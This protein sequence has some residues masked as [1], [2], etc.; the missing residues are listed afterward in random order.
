MYLKAGIKRFS[1]KI[2]IS[3]YLNEEEEEKAGGGQ[4]QIPSVGL[5]PL[6]HVTL[7]LTL[8]WKYFFITSKAPQMLG[9]CLIFWSSHKEH[10]CS[11]LTIHLLFSFL[12]KVSL[13]CV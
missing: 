7:A 4:E 5:F 1:Q 9:L 3:Q 10:S 2:I 12:V 8:N 6:S 13:S 11:T